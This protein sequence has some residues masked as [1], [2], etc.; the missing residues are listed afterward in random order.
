MT[1]FVLETRDVSYS[2][3]QKQSR[4]SLD[5]VSLGI[6]RGARTAI[7]GA[8]GAGKST[9]FYHL[10]GVYRPKSGTVL[11]EGEPIDYSKQSLRALRSEV[12]VVVQ[13]PDEQIFSSTVEEDIAFGLLNAGMERDEIERRIEESLFL[14]GMEG[15]RTRPS[16]QLSYGQRKRIAFAGALALR[17]KV[18]I[19]DEPTAGLD[20]QMSLE[21]VEMVDQL[22]ESGTSVVISTH[23]VDLAYTWAEDIHVIRGGRLEYSGGP[24]GFFSDSARAFSCG[25]K[26]P[27]PSVVDASLRPGSAMR[28]R[29][30]AQLLASLAPEGAV[31]GRVTVVPVEDGF[32][33][34][35]AS[36]PDGAVVGIYGSRTRRAFASGGIKVD[37]AFNAV[38]GCLADA[39]RGRDSVLFCDAEMAGFAERAG[40]AVEAFGKG[41]VM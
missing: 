28:P 10:N 41:A 11:Y 17:P 5:G 19:L 26:R 36:V 38:D 40:K 6:R 7:L 20:P 30:N 37:H 12:C 3:N 18:L 35:A 4:P 23:D 29:T 2:Y 32:D 27:T 8:N 13:N 24:D 16:T 9:L 1:D 34:S 39:V 22:V 33:A 21:V 14:V 25:L 15:Y 31:F